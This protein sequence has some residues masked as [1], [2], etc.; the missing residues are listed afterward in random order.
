M[1]YCGLFGSA[2][3]AVTEYPL[4][5]MAAVL[6]AAATVACDSETTST[7]PTVSLV[8]VASVPAP[9][10]MASQPLLVDQDLICLPASF[11]M[12]VR[13][14]HHLHSRWRPG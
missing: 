2:T 9:F 8:S 3:R 1:T 7:T 4:S 11:E 14:V 6:V 10:S 13:C 12:Q 5:T